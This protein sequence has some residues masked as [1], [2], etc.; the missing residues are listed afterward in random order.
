MANIVSP[1]QLQKLSYDARAFLEAA[2]FLNGRVYRGDPSRVLLDPR[3]HH[4]ILT[5][6]SFNF[7]VSLELTLKLIH[8]TSTGRVGE[9]THLCAEIYTALPENIQNTI[10]EI[11][12]GIGELHIAAFRFSKTTTPPEPPDSVPLSDFESI[13]RYFDYM[14][15]YL[16]RYSFENYNPESWMEFPYPMAG[17]AKLIASLLNT[18]RFIKHPR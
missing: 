11:Y 16:I 4:S 12:S 17:W 18:V 7:I 2:T 9:R 8:I 10:Q 14:K 6:M 1:E 15:M 5:A 3:E 13:L